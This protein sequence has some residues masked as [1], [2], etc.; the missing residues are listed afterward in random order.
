MRNAYL[1]PEIVRPTDG[2]LAQNACW[3]GG[4][5]YISVCNPQL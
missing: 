1:D 3:F 4:M 5:Q 2:F